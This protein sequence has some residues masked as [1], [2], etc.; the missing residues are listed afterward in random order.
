VMRFV[1][2]GNA[3]M[4]RCKSRERAGR[5][6]EAQALR[7]EGQKVIQ[8]RATQLRQRISERR[9]RVERLFADQASSAE[10]QWETLNKE[11]RTTKAQ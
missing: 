4:A 11:L 2:L 5:T 9:Q 3:Y 7:E 10:A 8:E 1:A 6:A